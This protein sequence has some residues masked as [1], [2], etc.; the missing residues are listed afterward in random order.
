MSQEG[1]NK[2]ENQKHQEIQKNEE[3]KMLE[4]QKLG[5]KVPIDKDLKCLMPDKSCKFRLNCPIYNIW[6]N[7]E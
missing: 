4:C 3:A 5:K 6:K 7:G 1:I 2:E